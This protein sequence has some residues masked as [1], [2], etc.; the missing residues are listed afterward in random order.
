M[1]RRTLLGG[2]CLFTALASLPLLA[3]DD[4]HGD[5]DFEDGSAVYTMTNAASGNSVMVYHRASNGS[6]T[7]IGPVATGGKGTGGGLGS[8]GALTLNQ[9]NR[10]LLAVNPA[11]DDVTVFRVSDSGLTLASR[12]PSGGHMPISATISGRTVYVLNA[13]MPNNISGF[14]LGHDGSLTPIPNS[15]RSLSGPSV[16]PAQV[17]FGHDGDELAVTEKGTN[18]IDIFPVASNGVPGTRVTT[19]S[20]GMTPFGFAFGKQNRLFVSEAAGGATNA[21]AASSYNLTAS[22][23]LQ[24]ISGSIKTNQTAACWLVIDP[25]G[26]YAYTTNTGSGTVSLYRIGKDGSLTL[27]GR[28]GATPAGGPIDAA[29]SGNGRFLSVLTA[30]AASI[31]TFHIAPDGSLTSVNT[32]MA[33][34]SAAGLAA[35]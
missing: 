23:T 19:P 17:Q 32:V 22:D 9:S 7:P 3:D 4:Q 25:S 26:R 27:D 5:F 16:G 11:S 34:A 14:T 21:S 12:T 6:L 10:W 29:F 28:L 15:M 1:F 35:Q 24:V 31:V 8:Q 30:N 33:P 18:L 2:V 13:G 20:A